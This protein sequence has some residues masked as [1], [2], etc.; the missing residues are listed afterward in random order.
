MTEDELLVVPVGHDLGVF[1][2]GGGQPPVRHEIRV[3]RITYGLPS[4]GE[5]QVWAMAHGSPGEPPLT[6][7]RYRSKLLALGV[8]NAGRIAGLL[9]G[10][11]LLCRVPPAGDAAI[12]FATRHRVVPLM[13]A[14]GVTDDTPHDRYTIGLF[15]HPVAHVDEVGYWLWFW[16]HLHDSLWLASEA[17][18]VV[19]REAGHD[20]DAAACL[21]LVLTRLHH[22]L[23]TS[24]AYLDASWDRR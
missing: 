1:H 5:H 11:G 12:G 3:G 8:P 18:A 20:D 15:G 9:A 7:P 17:L 4:A 19:R 21:T 10:D 16:G 6:W 22:L 13:T 2:P 23:A 24:A 14:L